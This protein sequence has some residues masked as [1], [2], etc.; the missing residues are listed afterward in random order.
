MAVCIS[1]RE[2]MS[3]ANNIAEVKSVF[4]TDEMMLEKIPAGFNPN[5]TQ[6]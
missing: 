2:R 6:V 1:A 3:E 4:M 5:F